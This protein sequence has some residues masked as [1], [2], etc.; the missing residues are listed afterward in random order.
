MRSPTLILEGVVLTTFH[1]WPHRFCALRVHLWHLSCALPGSHTGAVRHI[2]SLYTPSACIERGPRQLH[3]SRL[4]DCIQPPHRVSF[5]PCSPFCSHLW[6]YLC[7]FITTISAWTQAGC[8]NAD[9][10]PHAGL[11]D[12]FKNSLGSWCSTK[13]AGAI[14]FWLAFGFWAA[15][16]TLAVI[17]WRRDKAQGP[18]D[19]PFQHPEEHDY[20]EGDNTTYSPV[21]ASDHEDASP[22][23]DPRA[24]NVP[25]ASE[26]SVPTA[27]EYASSPSRP[28]Q[29]MDAYGAFS[30]P[31]PSGFDAPPV[32]DGGP[33]VSR[34]MQ[35]ADPYAVIR[36]KVA[37][38]NAPPSYTYQGY[39]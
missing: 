17:E 29:S 31:A 18:R 33:R 25:S 14:F 20:E 1:S 11:G 8:K 32:Q 15:S 16:L 34:T 10:D 13:K 21:R 19:P 12:S 28:R 38:S 22:F 37:P 36:G 26:Y 6:T 30:D 35:Y 9:N 3:S 23:A 24:S 27:S 7:R 4:R 39:P 5:P 2:R